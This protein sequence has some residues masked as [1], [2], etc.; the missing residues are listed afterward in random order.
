[1]RCMFTSAHEKESSHFIGFP[2]FPTANCYWPQALSR[3]ASA[4][5]IPFHPPPLVCSFG[6]SLHLPQLVYSPLRWGWQQCAPRRMTDE[7]QVLCAK[8]LA[9]GLSTGESPPPEAGERGMFT[10]QDF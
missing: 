9:P 5:L 4:H 2:W 8:G 6:E 7:V 3:W 10:A 1:M